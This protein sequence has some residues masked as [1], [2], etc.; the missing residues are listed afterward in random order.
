MF[1][2]DGRRDA[3]A[4]GE[5]AGD[6]HAAGLAGRDEVIEDLVGRGFV[7][8]ALVAIAGQVELQRLQ[9]DTRLVRACRRSG[10]R[11]NQAGRSSGTWT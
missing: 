6:A 7:E 11:R 1:G 2:D 3:A 8:D 9:L 5:R 4:G 10:S